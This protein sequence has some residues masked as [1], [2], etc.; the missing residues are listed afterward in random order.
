MSVGT[1]TGKVPAPARRTIELALRAMGGELLQKGVRGPTFAGA[2]TDSREVGP[3][4]LFFALPGERVD[5][6]QYG[7][8]AASAGAVGIVVA[9]GRG[10]PEGCAG[11]RSSP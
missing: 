4:Q 9:R 3:G 5:G 8:Q 6:F 11:W 1:E 2:A 10:I 7:A